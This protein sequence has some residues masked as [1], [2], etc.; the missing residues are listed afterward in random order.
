MTCLSMQDRNLFCLTYGNKVVLNVNLTRCT[1]IILAHAFINTRTFEIEWT[2]DKHVLQA[3]SN[4]KRQNRTKLLLSIGG[5]DGKMNPD[6]IRN[7]NKYSRMASSVKRRSTFIDNLYK[8]MNASNLDGAVF[9]WWNPIISGEQSSRDRSN[10]IQLLKEIKSRHGS[11]NPHISVMI[12]IERGYEDQYNLSSIEKESDFIL[13]PGFSKHNDYS[14]VWHHAPLMKGHGIPD[15]SSM[16]DV[17]DKLINVLQLNPEKLVIGI[18]AYG[19]AFYLENKNDFMPFSPTRAMVRSS[20]YLLKDLFISGCMPYGKICKIVMNKTTF[21][22][23]TVYRDPTNWIS[24]F[25]TLNRSDHVEW[26]AYEDSTS[27]RAMTSYIVNRG[28]RSV[29]LDNIDN[30]DLPGSCAG[31]SSSPTLLNAIHSEL[32]TCEVETDQHGENQ[33]IRANI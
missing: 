4:L 31:G 12:S 33:C 26:I 19:R 23:P 17:V 18:P 6:F 5:P 3:F 2:I 24:P 11:F 7:H 32:M 27:V 22:S 8:T 16:S 14:R 13:T 30:D 21:E 9:D 28:I 29:Y 10:F 15:K 25:L 20:C 1:H